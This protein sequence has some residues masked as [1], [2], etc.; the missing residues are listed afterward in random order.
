MSAW[1]P[2]RPFDG[3]VRVLGLMSGTSLDGI[4][5]ALLEVEERVGASGD[6]APGAAGPEAGDATLTAA[7]PPPS[8]AASL[9]WRLLAFRTRAYRPEERGALQAA[10]EAGGPRDLALLHT[11]LGEWL[12]DAVLDVLADHGADPATVAAIG[13]HGQTVWH[14]PPRG[15]ARGSSL[16]LGCPA[17]LAE[18]T[19]I[20]VVSDFRS[21]DLAAGGHGAP[22]VPWADRVLLSSP[23]HPRALQNLGGMGNVT[24]LPAAGDPAPLLAFDTGPG[25]ALLNIAAELATG[26]EWSFDQDGE[27]ALRGRVS[28]SLLAQLLGHPFFREEPP[29]S[30]GRETFGPKLVREASLALGRELGIQLL[31]G[32][33]DAGGPDLLATLTAL[34]ARSI[35]EAYRRWVLP[36][37]VREVVLLGGGARNPALAEAIRREL[38]PL[39]FLEGEAL[40]MDPDAREAVAFALLAWAHLRGVP[41]NVPEATGSRGPRILGCWTPG[42]DGVGPTA[43][44]AA[45]AART[46]A[47]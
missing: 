40:G 17:T 15:E 30:T 10:L 11:R 43:A 42:R 6:P 29:R 46:R 41:A 14:E 3:P 23:D 8:T 2:E 28:E 32:A 44:A 25:V 24:W 36:L 39:P 9:R 5:T 16:Q 45:A 4:D 31:A 1:L 33:P 47:S 13:S 19:G 7:A 26:G 35:G 27:L 37:G 21:R 34:T 38:S 18:R 20:G 22:L 12:A